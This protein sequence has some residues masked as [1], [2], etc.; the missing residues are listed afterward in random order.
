MHVNAAQLVPY[1]GRLDDIPGGLERWDAELMVHLSEAQHG[2][3]VR[4]DLLEIGTWLGRT[5]VLL[6]FL[7]GEGEQLQVCD[8]FDRVPATEEGRRALI[9]SGGQTVTLAD[10]QAS[11]A[12]FHST[13]PVVHQCPSSELSVTNVGRIFRFVHVDGSHVYEAVLE[14]LA[15]VHSILKKGGI[16]VFDDIANLG[17]LGVPAAVWS[18]ARATGLVPFACTPT[19]LYATLDENDAAAYAIVVADAARE[20]GHQVRENVVAGARIVGTWSKQPT[21]QQRVVRKARRAVR[22]RRR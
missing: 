18:G 19:K 17:H 6:G 8:L 21:L 14:D 11:Y 9:E 3:S 10:F 15:L 7:A 20:A 22:L 4:G 13:M 2:R 5:S 1:I 12:R 16:V